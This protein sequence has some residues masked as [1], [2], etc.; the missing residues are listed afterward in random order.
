MSNG[1]VRPRVLKVG[2]KDQTLGKEDRGLGKTEYICKCKD[3][4]HVNDARQFFFL[5]IDLD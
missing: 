1:L 5:N 2:R 3:L 4:E